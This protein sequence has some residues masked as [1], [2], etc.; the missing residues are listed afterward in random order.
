M[1]IGGAVIAHRDRDLA[2]LLGLGAVLRH[3]PPHGEAIARRDAEPAIG[4]VVAPGLFV[5]LTRTGLRIIRKAHDSNVAL[6]GIDRHAG[7]RDRADVGGAALIPY[8][9]DL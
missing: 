6:P 2:E 9:A 5:G 8:A 3:V 4:R 7:E 1:R